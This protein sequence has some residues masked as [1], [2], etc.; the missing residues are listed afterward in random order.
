MNFKFLKSTFEENPLFESKS[1]KYS[2][3]PFPLSLE[4]YQEIKD[5][6]VACCEFYQTLNFLYFASYNNQSIL[7]NKKYFVPWITRYY[8]YGKSD[9]LI[10]HA[11][12]SRLKKETPV[13][14][15][16]DLLL[17]DDGFKLTEMDSVP[18]GFG[19]T[20]FLHKLY[21]DANQEIQFDMNSLLD[22][23]YH[24]LAQLTPK[25]NILIQ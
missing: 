8:N 25:I 4:Q 11:L 18:G 14:M 5:I 22:L 6:G 20:T 23:Y 24:S 15:R 12:I 10:K 19:L 13:L 21:F 9:L 3:S 17:T 7:R 2:P 16:P 1:W